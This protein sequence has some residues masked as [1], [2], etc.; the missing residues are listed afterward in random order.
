MGVAAISD[1]ISAL[2]VGGRV[3][4]A[5]G[6]A[7][8]EVT[9]D[10]MIV[11]AKHDR[12]W[13]AA[14]TLGFQTVGPAA[15]RPGVSIADP[16]PE[17]IAGEVLRLAGVSGGGFGVLPAART[18]VSRDAVLPRFA[19]DEGLVLVDYGDLVHHLWLTVSLVEARAQAPVPTNAGTFDGHVF[20]SLVDGLE[21]FALVLGDVSGG[22]V[23]TRVHSECLTGDVFGSLR[24]DCGEQL[25]MALDRVASERRGVIVYVRGH[26]GRGIGLAEKL[27]AYRLQDSGRD[28][29][30][31]NLELGHSVDERHYGVAAQ[32]LS[33]LGIAS[34]VLLTNNPA[35]V[36]GLTELGID[37]V[38]RLPLWSE[39]TLDNDRY[40]A[41][42]RSH[43]GHLGPD[44]G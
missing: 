35:K 9:A 40:L 30:E 22:S 31:A 13:F 43:L 6:L 26:E 28:T 3:L 21:H 7:K 1:A 34:V 18:I 23:M 39:P 36:A 38:G 16:S 19:E 37:V 41:T 20:T 5:D 12:P 2:R 27:R 32:V 8:G 33:L 29:I 44:A 17:T 42:K 11:A 14:R 25:S 15:R 10:G 24:C 4:I